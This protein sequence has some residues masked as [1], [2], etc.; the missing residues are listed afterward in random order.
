[1]PPRAPAPRI[2]CAVT[3]CPCTRRAL[4]HQQPVDRWTF[5]CPRHWRVLTL[6]E[7]KVWRRLH[8]WWVGGDGRGMVAGDILAERGGRGISRDAVD[9]IWAGLVRRAFDR[10]SPA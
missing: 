4:P 1:M 9:R 5:L 6:A 3:F 7:R 10:S 8:R 2:R